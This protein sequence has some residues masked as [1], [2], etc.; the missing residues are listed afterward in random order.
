M[1]GGTARLAVFTRFPSTT[2]IYTIKLTYCFKV[3]ATDR[4]A[5]YRKAAQAMRE[6]PGAFIS[7]VVEGEFLKQK[8]L[9]H[10]LVFGW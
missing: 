4:T 8:S 7:Q 6:E 2:M 10:R 3:E 1:L 9:W 5:A